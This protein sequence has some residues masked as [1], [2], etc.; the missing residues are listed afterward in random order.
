MKLLKNSTTRTGVKLKYL[1]TITVILAGCLHQVGD[2]ESNEDSV[3]SAAKQATENTVQEN[4][5]E[6]TVDDVWSMDTD[7]E[8]CADDVYTNYL[9][10]KYLKENKD[11]SRRYKNRRSRQLYR[12]RRETEATYFARSTLVGSLP[13]YFGEL[14]VTMNG[15]VEYWVQYFKTRGRQTFLK[16]LIRAASISQTVGPLLEKEKM[17]KELFFLAMIESG[18]NF[19]ARSRARA[20]G[21]WQFM[22]GTGKVYGLKVNFWVDERNDPVKSTIAAATFLRDLYEQFGDWYLAI[23]A[24]NAGPAKVRR[25]IRKLKTRNF[26]KIAETRYLRVET[27]QYVPKLLAALLIATNLKQHGFDIRPSD[28]E[29]FPSSF[30]TFNRAAKISEVAKVTGIPKKEIKKWNPELIRDVIPPEDRDNQPYRLRIPPN[31][32]AA[33]EEA[34]P[35]LSYLA[36]KE[37]KIHR[38]RQ[39]DTLYGLARKYNVRLKS[40]LSINPRLNPKTLRIGKKV[41]I[42]I[43]DVVVVKTQKG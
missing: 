18:F 34:K 19:R 28:Y 8:F 6:E 40:I 12:K 25:A 31:Y 20:M 30:V 23:A 11:K 4:V 10:Q 15:K 43:P 35:N 27:K 1:L 29:M 9:R 13:D 38:V 14:P 3:F 36:L 42:P 37:V 41:A 39:G 7:D 22:H 26:W 17:P 2:E 5:E 16:W 32:V 33:I 24:Y 21:P